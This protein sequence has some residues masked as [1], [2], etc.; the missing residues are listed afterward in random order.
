MARILGALHVLIF[1][2]VA[3]G[4]GSRGGLSGERPTI[5]RGRSWFDPSR[6]TQSVL[7]TG[8]SNVQFPIPR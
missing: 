7:A 4:A 6:T 3:L 1:S 5:T 8:F 2:L